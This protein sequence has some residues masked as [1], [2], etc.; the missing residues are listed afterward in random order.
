MTRFDQIGCICSD[1]SCFYCQFPRSISISGPMG[2]SRNKTKSDPK[3]SGTRTFRPAMMSRKSGISFTR[4]RLQHFKKGATWSRRFP[5]RTFT[6]DIDIDGAD[7]CLPL[8]RWNDWCGFTDGEK[9]LCMDGYYEAVNNK[10]CLVYSF[11][12]CELS[13]VFD[14]LIR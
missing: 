11:G 6:Y 8:G 3:K 7:D 9:L 1:Y 2:F 5:V 4:C 10:S 13:K 14:N 12:L